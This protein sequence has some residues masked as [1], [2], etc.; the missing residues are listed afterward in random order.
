MCSSDLDVPGRPP[1]PGNQVL[2]LVALEI[3]QVD[4]RRSEL[5]V[6]LGVDGSAR[7]LE[8]DGVSRG[9]TLDLRHLAPVPLDRALDGELWFHGLELDLGNVFDAHDQLPWALHRLPRDGAERWAR[10]RPGEDELPIGGWSEFRFHLKYRVRDL[11]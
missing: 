5:E 10:F 9:Q 1:G 8:R 4:E 7:K 3:D 2:D 11:Q 6:H